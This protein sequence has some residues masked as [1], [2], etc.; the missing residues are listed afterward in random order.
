MPFEEDSNYHI[1]LS[2]VVLVE[3]AALDAAPAGEQDET[4]AA[5]GSEA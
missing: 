4:A 1:L 3:R 5:G 2:D